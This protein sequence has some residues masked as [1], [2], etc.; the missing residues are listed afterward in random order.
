MRTVPEEV[1]VRHARRITVDSSRGN[2]E[3]GLG[4]NPGVDN[5]NRRTDGI[6][7]AVDRGNGIE[8]G[9]YAIDTGRQNLRRGIDRRVGIDPPHD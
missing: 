1:V 7:D 9:V 4:S 5:G 3:I 6:V 2:I 8:I